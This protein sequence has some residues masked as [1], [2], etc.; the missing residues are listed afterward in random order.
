MIYKEQLDWILDK[1]KSII[2]KY[3]EEELYKL[4]IDFVHSLGE[5]CDCV[6]W[7]SLDLNS[8]NAFVILG[9]IE[10]FCKE[11]GFAARG[12]YTRTLIDDEAQ[13]FELEAGEISD[14]AL[15]SDKETV[16]CKDGKDISYEKINASKVTPAPLKMCGWDIYA[17]EKI[18]NYFIANKIDNVSFLWAKDKG[19][20][21]ATQ[22]FLLHPHR[23]VRR[24]MRDY[25]YS[26]NGKSK[27][28]T[29]IAS[30]LGG[31]LPEVVKVFHNLQIY[32]PDGYFS[33][34]LPKD[35]VMGVYSPETDNAYYI[36]KVLIH[37]D[38]AEKM[39]SENL[40]KRKNLV[41]V[42]VSKEKIDGYTTCN[43]LEK[44]IPEETEVIRLD[45][46]YEKLSEK[47]RPVKNITEKDALKLLRQ[48]KKEVPEDFSKAISLKTCE[49]L[50]KTP[51]APLSVYYRISNGALI[52][53]EYRFLSYNDSKSET[54]T[55]IKETAD[56]D[57]FN[58]EGIVIA[59]C[60]DGDRVTL[61]EDGKV[62]R[63]SHED[64]CTVEEFPSLHEFFYEICSN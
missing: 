32:L 31:M 27:R 47:D 41:P 17:S 40:I 61:D 54:E 1:K 60:T 33:E 16:R 8:D 56:E 48:L 12:I 9:K 34:D 37:K 10:N 51:Y 38:S 62:H 26:Y 50:S 7:S 52:G 63:I 25:D 57:Y 46:E 55:F 5:K 21:K 3:S 23:Y 43:C 22:Y 64:L 6:G 29:E 39:L 14:S 42:L 36:I 4:R 24:I 20:Y 59:V 11:N 13:W 2:K 53:D 44:G 58:F 30:Q 49:E 18:R 28:M 35:G 45:S 15:T 19:K